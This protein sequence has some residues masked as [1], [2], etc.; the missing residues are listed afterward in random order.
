MRVPRIYTPLALSAGAQVTLD[1]RASHY[2]GQVLRMKSGRELLLFNGDGLAYPAAIIKADKKQVVCEL[3]APQVPVEPL[4]PVELELG[5]AISKGDRMDWVV[6][7]AT[8]LGVSRISP[9]STERVD[10]KLS[11]ERLEKKQQH[12]WQVMVSACEQCGRNRLP[13]MAPLQT[14]AQWRS[15]LTAEMKLVLSPTAEAGL[16]RATAPHSVALLVGPEGGLTDGELA[17]SEQEGFTSLQL[18]P[19]ILRTET[20]PL[21]ALAILQHRWG[22]MG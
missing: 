9:L 14:L 18:G 12:W 16:E 7:K 10:V 15:G 6:Q 11:G 2:L 22:D 5:I 19:R 4:P 21:A 20:A 13:D 1:P 8:E 3:G 17:E